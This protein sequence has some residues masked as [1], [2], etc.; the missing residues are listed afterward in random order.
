VRATD[1]TATGCA[2]W[3]A[4]ALVI[5]IALVGRDAGAA[6]AA[7]GLGTSTQ[8]Y[9]EQVNALCQDRYDDLLK[10]GPFEVPLDFARRGGKRIQLQSDFRRALDAL[11]KP[12]HDA[13]MM[14]AIKRASAEAD[15]ADR[16]LPPL[17]KAA[18][19]GQH[20]AWRLMYR[21][22]AHED[23]AGAIA[24]DNGATSCRDP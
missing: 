21:W 8:Q 9:L 1:Q 24:R 14:R 20:K 23:R 13:R 4:V 11:E 12:V 7:P 5:L 10:L 3:L 16:L 2:R 18:R 22:R 15:A 17:V 19:R 6:Q